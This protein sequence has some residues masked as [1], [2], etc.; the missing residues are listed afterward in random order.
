[1]KSRSARAAVMFLSRSREGAW[2]EIMVLRYATIL[3]P[4][5][6]ARERGLKYYHICRYET[7]PRVAPAREHGLK[8]ICPHVLLIYLRRSREGA[9]IEM[10]G[11]VLR[12]FL[13]GCRSREG[14]WIEIH[15][16]IPLA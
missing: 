14:A 16:R 6:P 15:I 9:W 12:L 4:V 2:I 11:D 8:S 1:M 7:C 5:A 13:R 3:W 10:P